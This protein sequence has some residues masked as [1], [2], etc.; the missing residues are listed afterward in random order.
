MKAKTMFF[1]T[2]CGNETPKWE[3]RCRAC[4]AWNSITEQPKKIAASEPSGRT[5]LRKKPIHFSELDREEEIRFSTG[6]TE[7]DRVLGGGAVRGSLVLFGGAPGIGKSTLLLQICQYI[8]Q[9]DTVLYIT[10]E[11]S[12]KQ[13]GMRGTRLGIESD[14]LLILSETSIEEILEAAAEIQPGLL[15]IDSIQTMYTDSASSAAG[16]VAQV[17]ACTMALMHYGKNTGTTIFLIGHVNKEGIIAG[18]KVLEHMVDCVMYFEGERSVNFRILRAAKNRYGSTN[19]IGVFDMTEDGLIQIDNPS[20]ALLA[21]RPSDAPG[22][23]VTCVMEGSRPVLA[24][25]QG[26]AVSASG[27]PRR[28]TNGIDYNRANM[29]IAI[30]DKRTGYKVN[31][32]DTYI[33]VIGGLT[34]EDPGAD[35]AMILAIAS[36]MNGKPIPANLTAIGEVGLTGEIRSASFFDQ[37]LKEC[38]KHGFSRCII[39]KANLKKATIP[40][41]LT[42]I[43]AANIFDA[44]R[45]VFA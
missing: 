34:I 11:E 24:E 4:G 35:L 10:G 40:D 14:N 18:P 7:L 29:M 44:L 8:C 43:P 27:N 41:N 42:L 32:C 13:I 28:N 25:I 26:L 37:R 33:N 5:G 22:T 1:C 2:E 9:K 6:M 30:M 20:A 12:E 16:S 31:S 17:K 19:E 38:V 15:I 21:E 45:I 39:P 36:A 3:G 23:C